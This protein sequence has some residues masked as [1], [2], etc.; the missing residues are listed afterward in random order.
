[1]APPVWSSLLNEFELP[2]AVNIHTTAAIWKLCRA[3][4]LRW[5]RSTSI[6]LRGMHNLLSECRCNPEMWENRN[7]TTVM[8]YILHV[9]KVNFL[10]NE[11]SRETIPFRA[12]YLLCF[13]FWMTTLYREFQTVPLAILIEI[14]FYNIVSAIYTIK[15]FACFSSTWRTFRDV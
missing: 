7:G 4:Y 8:L 11:N 2:M 10:V 15:K 13:P 6:T 5:P 9:S 1:M 14:L 12:F 3:K